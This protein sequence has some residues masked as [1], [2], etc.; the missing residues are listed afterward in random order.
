MTSLLK[1]LSIGRT[2]LDEPGVPSSAPPRAL[3]SVA[4]FSDFSMGTERDGEGWKRGRGG[5]QPGCRSIGASD[6]PP[7]PQTV[8]RTTTSPRRS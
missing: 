2:R 7:L 1:R 3:T 8:Q 6:T 5:Q 4:S